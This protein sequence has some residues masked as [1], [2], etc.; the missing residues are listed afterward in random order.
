[1]R[2][3]TRTSIVLLGSAALVSGIALPASADDTETTV[4]VQGGGLAISSIPAA[5]DF[6]VFAPGTAT[7]PGTIPGLTV[8]DTRAGVT[9]W[10]VSVKLSDFTSSDSANPAK[11]IPASAATYTPTGTAASGVATVTPA[12]ATTL[13]TAGQP[14]QTAT[15]VSGNNGATWAADLSVAI[16][17]DALA[18]H[19]TATLTHS[20]L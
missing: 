11:V 15:G 12:G 7:I 16:P 14:I 10:A 1:M 13:A 17:S 8:T 4:Q 9:G 5:L 3:I 19:Y 2:K 6:G 20:V 18:G